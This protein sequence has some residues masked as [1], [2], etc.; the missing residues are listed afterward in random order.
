MAVVSIGTIFDIKTASS[1]QQID[2]EPIR[3]IADEVL[4]QRTVNIDYILL[5]TN[6]TIY[7]ANEAMGIAHSSNATS[8]KAYEKA[9]ESVEL[10][11]NGQQAIDE[12]QATVSVLQDHVK[13]AQSDLGDKYNGLVEVLAGEVAKQKEIMVDLAKKEKEI[14]FNDAIF[15]EK[16]KIK[17]KNKL[18]IYKQTAKAAEKEKWKNIRDIKL[19]MKLSLAII[20]VSFFIY[21]IKYGIPVLMNYLVQ[22]RVISETSRGWVKPKKNINIDGLIFTPSLQKQLSD[23]LLRAQSAKKYNEVLPNILFHGASGTGKTAFAKALAYASGLDYALT[24]GSEFLKI[25]DLRIAN[26]ELRKL[27]DWAKKGKKGLIVFI[28]E[29]ES[30]FANRRLSTTPRATQDFINT[31]LS[32]ISDQSQK[33]LMF[34]F[35]TNHPFK[36]DDAIIN[37]IGINVEFTLPQPAERE[38]ILF[39]YLFKFAQENKEAIVD[40]QPVKKKLSLYTE[41]LDG[42]SPRAIKFVAQEMIIKARRQTPRQLTDAIAQA[43]I[44]DAKRSL[45]EAEQWKEERAQLRRKMQCLLQ[46]KEERDEWVEA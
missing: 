14:N 30:L 46:S 10:L 45:Q 15:L 35:A 17:Y 26:D 41:S 5:N 7:R 34:I 44:D 6:N 22:P 3:R 33:K 9:N 25:T 43:I 18:G 2:Q 31:F 32:L 11:K 29:A 37:R 4:A 21:T 24:S 36:L 20:A 8:I 19:I 42:F 23:L 39:M 27:L 40:L 16:E 28:D 13:T 12:L 38:K 1:M